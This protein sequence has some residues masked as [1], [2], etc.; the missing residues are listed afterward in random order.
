MRRSRRGRSPPRTSSFAS[1]QLGRRGHG[2][3]AGAGVPHAGDAD[4]CSAPPAVGWRDAQYWQ[5]RVGGVAPA[6]DKVGTRRGGDA[7]TPH[8]RGKTRPAALPTR[9]CGRRCGDRDVGGRRR[10]RLPPTRID[11]AV[12]V[13]ATMPV[14]AYSTRGTLIGAQRL[15]PW[16]GGT[17]STGSVAYGAWPQRT[18]RSGRDGVATPQRRMGAVKGDKPPCRRVV[19]DADAAT[20]TGAVVDVDVFLRLGSTRPSLSRR[21]C[22]CWRTPIGG[23]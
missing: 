2:G 21:R 23:R 13:M 1:N 3:D 9:R 14:L 11:S 20:E 12:V 5:R 6:D 8:G 18:K 19:V 22:R 7:T 16:D 17:P 10:R 15:L 4:W